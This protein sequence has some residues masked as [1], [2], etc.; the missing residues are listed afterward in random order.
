[1]I[2][3]ITNINN[4]INGVVWGWPALILLGFVGVLMTCLTKFFQITHIS[5]WMKNTIGAIFKDKHVIGHTGDRTISQFQS[6]CT[7]L[8]ATVGTG[9]IVGVAGA[10]AT[11]GPGAVFWMWLIAFCGMM[12]N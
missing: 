2:E 8:A 4:A 3:I 6:L 1:M 5:H 7:A 11:G 10:I 12:T 9:N